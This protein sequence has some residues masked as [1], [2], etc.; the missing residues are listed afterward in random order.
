[1]IQKTQKHKNLQE[2]NNAVWEVRAEEV[3]M[4]ELVIMT[5]RNRRKKKRNTKKLVSKEVHFK[6]K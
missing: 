4:R 6:Q 1:M 3:Q 5:R 2:L